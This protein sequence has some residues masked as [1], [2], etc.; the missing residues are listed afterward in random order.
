MMRIITFVVLTV[1][2]SAPCSGQE[3]TVE[4]AVALALRQNRE[5]RALQFSFESSGLALEDAANEFRWAIVP[6]G[7][8]GYAE[9]GA[10]SQIGL[11]VRR[12]SVWGT[13]IE[14]GARMVD[15]DDATEEDID[16]SVRVAIQQPLLKMRGRLSNE[17]GIRRAESGVMSAR[18]RMDLQ[19]ADLVVRVVELHQD[20]ARLQNQMVSDEQSLKRHD[21]LYR[22][23][24][25]REAQGRV[26]RVDLLRT[27]FQRGRAESA[28]TATRQQLEFARRDLADTL[29]MPPDTGYI[30]LPATALRLDV[31]DPAIAEHVALSNRLDFADAL[32]SLRDARRGVRIARQ[33][34]RPTLDLVTRYERLGTGSGYGDAYRLDDELWFV[35]VSGDTDLY[36]RSERL[37]LGQAR[38]DAAGAENQ[39]ELLANS[40][41]RQVQQALIAYRQAVEQADFAARNY[42]LARD[43]ARLARRLFDIGRGDNFTVTDAE[44]ELFQA[45]SDML[46]TRTESTVAAYRVLQTLGTLIEAPEELKPS[47]YDAGQPETRNAQGR[48]SSRR[49]SKQSRGNETSKS[50]SRFDSRNFESLEPVSCPRVLGHLDPATDT[51]R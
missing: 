13:Q 11:G 29:G 38:L 26:T 18:R 31:T 35:G 36:R 3:I 4:Q 27:E 49:G 33:N 5:L 21:Q 10:A 6:E 43:R 51:E 41:R 17:E 14:T 20:L 7:S 9:N 50:E 39:I 2:A 24:R 40:I 15:R 16:S 44:A 23:T 8:A 45:E 42:Q 30:A 47:R 32:Q 1:A 37:A 28:L 46:R 25:A 34:L 12:K 48:E 19:R 22:L